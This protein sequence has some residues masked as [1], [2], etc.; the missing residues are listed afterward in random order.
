MQNS[1]EKNDV[2]I[3]FKTKPKK[4]QLLMKLQIH[5][6]RYFFRKMQW[7]V[8]FKCD[9]CYWQDSNRDISWIV[10][11]SLEQLCNNDLS[12]TVKISFQGVI[13]DNKCFI[14]G[15][16]G[17][18]FE[19]ELLQYHNMTVNLVWY[20]KEKYPS[21]T[22]PDKEEIYSIKLNLP[23]NGINP[24]HFFLHR[25]MNRNEKPYFRSRTLQV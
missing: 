7:S 3:N 16:T 5:T 25:G 19:S 14:K 1:I 2:Q 10:S 24:S 11:V 15:F 20:Y 8:F 17:K 23:I 9:W 21:W 22:L 6:K 13:K 12:N 18:W 4:I